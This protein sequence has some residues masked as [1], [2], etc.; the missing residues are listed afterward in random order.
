MIAPLLAL[1]PATVEWSPKVA[2]VMIVCNVIAI[3]IGKATIKYPNEGAQLPNSAFFGGMGHAALLATTSLGH[4]FG[5]G[6]IQGL[7]AR[8]VL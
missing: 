1:A 7:A 6:A 2:L 8:G 5:I 3:A 4:L